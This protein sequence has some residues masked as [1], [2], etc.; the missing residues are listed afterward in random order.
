[1]MTAPTIIAV[2]SVDAIVRFARSAP[3]FPCRL[4][5]EEQIVDGRPITRKAKSPLTER[6]FLDASQ[7][8]GRIRS[9][10]KRY[11][12]A[13]VGVPTGVRTGLI[14]IDYDPGKHTDATGEWIEN[15][16]EA[17]M[18]ARVHITGR[19]GRHYLYRIP[20]GHHYH[21]GVDLELCG[22]KRPGIDLRANGGYVIWWPLHGLQVTND[23]AP[24]LPAGLIEE[25]AS[26]HRGEAPAPRAAASPEKWAKDRPLVVNALAFLDPSGYDQW[27]KVGQAIHLA[28]GANDEGFQLW[29]DWSAGAIT[30]AMPNN[31]GG[32]ELCRFKW[33]SFNK[34]T[35]PDTRQYT[36]GSLFHCAKTAGYVGPS[37][38]DSSQAHA[39]ENEYFEQP[40]AG[41]EDQNNS[42]SASATAS[43]AKAAVIEA[44]VYKWRDPKTIPPRQW[45]Y[46][47]HYM[48][49]MVSV[50]AG[51]GGAGKSTLLL[52]EAIS[53]ALG[54]DLLNDGAATLV[55]PISVWLHN[56]EDPY[57]ELE[58]RIGAVLL[59]YQ[60]DP[61]ELGDR[62]YVTSGRD[63]RIIVA[64]ELSGGGKL[65][66][67]SESIKQVISEIQKRK[68][69][70]F[71]ADPF[72]TIHKV[73][74]NDNSMID[75]VM[76][77]LRDAAHASGCAVEVAHH[78]RKLNGDEPSVD[79]IRGA[80]SIIGA[81]RS[82]RIIAGMTKEEAVKY[83][84]E[85]DVRGL[86][87]W[88]Q[89]GKANMLPPTHKRRWLRMES[90]CLEN[91]DEEHE[92]DN[93][94]VVT[95]WEPP[96]V[97]TDI[98]GPEYRMLRRAIKEANPITE[99]RQDIRSTGW[100]GFLIAKVLERDGTDK[101]V[102]NQIQSVIARLIA[103]G[104]LVKEQ[105]RDHAKGRPAPVLVWKK[106]EL[107][108]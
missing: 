10:W 69:Q 2:P 42:H 45:L 80:S 48:R 61:D 73:N 64:A 39:D 72:V 49:G 95:S 68:I 78:F 75:D 37:Q 71:I 63:M 83:A 60:I 24:L 20:A 65:L 52:V 92:A 23:I 108:E 88:L 89:N 38:P 87:S 16:T 85:D 101:V 106:E 28:T 47:K 44:R 74:E 84:I 66:V 90:V 13:L 9:W 6:G 35:N 58:R 62:L 91:G 56:G 36:L 26:K 33:A 5:D 22:K 67:A 19:S 34:S 14:A 53:M 93:I 81:A 55:G 29:H 21:S 99:L 100:I 104:S 94:G 4:K 98:S 27:I 1:M 79:S 3:V 54:R 17:L 51:I 103:N 57:E 32:I 11:P 97:E 7:E 31:Y 59:Q 40:L 50:T 96:E 82:A 77:L 46:G 41:T 12:D 43:E 70:A 8:E 18:C 102:K 107:S 76:T 15:N 30:G 105:M 86:Y 25:R